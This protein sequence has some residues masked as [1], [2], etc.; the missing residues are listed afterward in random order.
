MT[1]EINFKVQNEFNFFIS[2]KMYYI[3]EQTFDE[4][5][6][7]PDPE[8]MPKDVKRIHVFKD[9]TFEKRFYFVSESEMMIYRYY[10]PEEYKRESGEMI[11]ERMYPEHPNGFVK[12][13]YYRTTRTTKCFEMIPDI[14][15]KK[16]SSCIVSN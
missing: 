15:S 1:G 14:S 9:Y 4:M 13:V 12:R 5:P 7:K 10:I 3:Y 16:R 2:I 11:W 8:M 6:R